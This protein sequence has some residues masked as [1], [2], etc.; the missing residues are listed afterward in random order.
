MN[1]NNKDLEILKKI[2]DYCN[3]IEAAII[4]FGDD[5]NV[6]KDD[7]IYVHACTMCILQVGELCKHLS[8]DFRQI[9]TEIPWGS[10]KAMRNIFAHNY[11]KLDLEDAWDTVKYDIPI[12]KEFCLKKLS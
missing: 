9:N 6:F 3:D 4:R 11:G 1:K 10:I 8:D 2:I 7:K 12:L 5:Y